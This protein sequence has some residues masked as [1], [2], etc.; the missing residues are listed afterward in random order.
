MKVLV[1]L[2]TARDE[3]NTISAVHE[4]CPYS[5]FELV[6]LRKLN[7]GQYNYSAQT[8]DDFIYVAQKMQSSD[9]IVFATPVYWYSMS[10]GLKTLFDR[11]SDLLAELKPIGKSLAGKRTFLVATGSEPGLPEGFEVPFRRTSEYFGMI[12]EKAFYKCVR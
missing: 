11:L 6:D 12:Y 7:I 1:I 3:S 5:D 8:T 9:V 2:G 10:A 4:L